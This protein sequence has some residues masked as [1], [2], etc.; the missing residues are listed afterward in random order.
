MISGGASLKGRHIAITGGTSHTGRRLAGRLLGEGAVLRCLSHDPANRHRLPEAPES[1]M[2]IISGSADKPEDLEKMMDGADTL[3]HLAG[4]LFTPTIIDFLEKRGKPVRLLVQSSTRRLSR[5]DTPTRRDVI[6][7]EEAVERS[8]G[9]IN[10]TILRPA[11]IFGGP[12]DNNI[13]R[14]AATLRRWRCFPIFGSG[15]NLIQPLF[16]L[17]LV[18]A[19]IAALKRPQASSGRSYT[20]AGPEAMPYRDFVKKVAHAAGV[21]RVCLIPIPR[22]PALW[23]AK[24]IAA[25]WR[26]SP[27]NPEAIERFGEDRAFDISP[28]REGLAYSPTAFEE[29]LEMK[30][31]GQL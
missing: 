12:D 24:C 1:Q 11:M 23:T 18:E 16:V 17:D 19:H 6:A 9:T 26:K 25:L 8:S 10:W 4:Q 14:L 20:L 7:S 22:K 2:S 15:E 21:K 27:V 28:A 31:S 30:F 3:I 29:A 5:F 13:E